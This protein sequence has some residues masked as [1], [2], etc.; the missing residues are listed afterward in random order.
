MSP[1]QIADATGAAAIASCRCRCASRTSPPVPARRA[2]G[3]HAAPYEEGEKI[4]PDL[5]R[6]ACLIGLEGLVSKYRERAYCAG[7]CTHWIKVKNPKHPAYQRAQDQ[8]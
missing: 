4:G 5:F 3:I 8:F 2:D 1:T 7:R 6:H